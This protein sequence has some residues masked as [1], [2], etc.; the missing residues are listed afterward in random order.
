MP[1]LHCAIG[2]DIGG[3]STKLARVSAAG[4]VLRLE[5]VPT[6]IRGDPQPY[7]SA[8]HQVVQA[9]REDGP[10]CGVGLS[11]NGMLTDDLRSAYLSPNS[12]ALVGIDFASWLEGF[13]CP[14]AIDEDLN[15]PT[16][17]EYTFGAHAGC[18]RLMTASIG[19][20][21][22]AGM[23]VKGKVL[24]FVGGTIGDTGHIILEP[25]GP[26][27]TAGCRGCAEALI[28]APGIE[29]L[30]A[31]RGLGEIPA[32]QVIGAARSG[33]AWAVEIIAQVGEYLGQWL[34]SVSPI[35]LPEYVLVCGGIAEAGQTLLDTAVPRYHFLSGPDYA[36][37]QLGLSRFGGLAGVI[38]AAAPLLISEA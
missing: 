18:A 21:F 17:A 15:A 13:G 20:G 35:F 12:P 19:T 23:M 16:V 24:R 34:A 22:G 11:L 5:Q 29:R 30:A 6:V 1:D 32:R 25:G 9:L 4:S 3:T 33:E 37:A 31:A 2:I 7:L 36:R 26:A 8:L 14:Y 28:S 27:C 10:V 38:G